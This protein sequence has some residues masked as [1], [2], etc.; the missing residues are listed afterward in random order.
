[1]A[2]VTKKSLLA[3]YNIPIERLDFEYIKKTKNVKELERIYKILK[4]GEE[5]Y[6]PDL[7]KCAEN[8]LKILSPANRLLRTEE[9]LQSKEGLDKHEW[10]AI[11]NE[12][13]VILTLLKM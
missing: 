12:I 2:S 4:S 10:A 6:Y 9:P 7:T 8:H 3:K 11:N 1:M 13:K 5:G